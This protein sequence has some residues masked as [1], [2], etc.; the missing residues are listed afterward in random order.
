MDEKTGFLVDLTTNAE[1]LAVGANTWSR[2][3][4]TTGS[5][6]DYFDG[7]IEDFAIFDQAL[8]PAEQDLWLA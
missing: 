5:Y 6:R 8:T 3:A 2:T 1:S 4:G 7:T